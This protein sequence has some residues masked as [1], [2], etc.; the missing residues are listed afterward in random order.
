M[1]LYNQ[2]QCCRPSNQ[3]DAQGPATRPA[4]H[5]PDARLPPKQKLSGQGAAPTAAVPVVGAGAS[6]GLALVRQSSPLE[7]SAGRFVVSSFSASCTAR[8]RVLV[9]PSSRYDLYELCLKGALGDCSPDSHKP[10]KIEQAYAATRPPAKKRPDQ[11]GK[12]ES[13][14]SFRTCRRRAVLKF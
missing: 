2:C 13:M 10:I 1:L 6:L 9:P 7:L 4:L 8:V 3:S 12:G 14:Q 5:F 11:S